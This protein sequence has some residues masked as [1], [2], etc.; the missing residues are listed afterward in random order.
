MLDT[1]FRCPSIISDFVSEAFYE[2]KYFAGVGMDK[3][4]AASFVLSP[5]YD[6]V[7][8]L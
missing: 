8:H 4:K 2:G 6:L 5:T 1:Q 7:R 3:E